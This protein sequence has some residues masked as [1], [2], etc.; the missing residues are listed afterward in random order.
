MIEME[1]L[2]SGLIGALAATFISVIYLHIS[3]KNK[4]RG[5]VFLEVVGYCDDIYHYLQKLHVYKDSEY[6]THSVPFSPD[7]YKLISDKL[8]VLLLSSKV[9]AKLTL[10][11]GEGE[12]LLL[13]NSLRKSFNDVSSTL[14][15]AT[16]SAWVVKENKEIFRLFSEEIEPVRTNLQTSLLYGTMYLPTLY[17]A[18][19][20]VKQKSHNK[21]VKNDAQ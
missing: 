16:R 21:R 17:K 19:Q 5:E 11:Y 7:D 13:F 6:T 20:Y 18:Y 4:L 14:R 10:A 15:K 1:Q 12:T 9:H 2:L 8:T 3:E